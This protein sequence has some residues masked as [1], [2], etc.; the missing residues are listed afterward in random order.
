MCFNKSLLTASMAQLV[1]APALDVFGSSFTPWPSHTHTKALTI[2]RFICG[3]KFQNSLKKNPIYFYFLT[4]QSGAFKKLFDLNASFSNS[5]CAKR[6]P[7]Y[8][9]LSS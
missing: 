5:T 9:K 4:K 2:E 3:A 6:C 7:V 1:R 8:F